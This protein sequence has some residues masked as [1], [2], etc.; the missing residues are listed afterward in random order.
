[1]IIFESILTTFKSNI[2]FRGSLDSS[3]NWLEPKIELQGSLR[4]AIDNLGVHGAN[5]AKNPDLNTYPRVVHLLKTIFE[6]SAFNSFCF[7]TFNMQ[8]TAMKQASN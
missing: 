8:A 4:S 2:V 3:D 7:S 6:N 5:K 1:M